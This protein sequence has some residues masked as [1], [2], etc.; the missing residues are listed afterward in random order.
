MTRDAYFAARG[1]EWDRLQYD[2]VQREDRARERERFEEPHRYYRPE[3]DR[4]RVVRL[5]EALERLISTIGLTDV[6][7]ERQRAALQE[8]VDRGYRALKLRGAA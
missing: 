8:A 2:I 3:S 6:H 7:N 5:E 1:P 4:A